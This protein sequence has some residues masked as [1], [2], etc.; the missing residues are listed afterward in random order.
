M[1]LQTLMLVTALLCAACSRG[2]DAKQ[3]EEAAAAAALAAAS[4]CNSAAATSWRVANGA[5]IQITGSASGQN[6][7]T[8][9][10][11]LSMRDSGGRILFGEAFDADQVMTLAGKTNAAEM[12]A[13]LIEWLTPAPSMQTSSTLPAW[14][15]GAPQPMSGEF[16]F[17]P[18]PGM[19]RSAYLALRGRNA[20]MFCYAQG[21]ESLGCVAFE[22]ETVTKVGVQTFPG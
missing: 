18:D 3:A 6:C 15:A 11:S 7:A 20:P 21:M 12:Q 9:S 14:P 10:V 22:N 8:A 17:Y 2:D 19:E 13:A 4:A 16:P 1:R 5:D